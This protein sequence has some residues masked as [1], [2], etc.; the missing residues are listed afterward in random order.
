MPTLI[1]SLVV[2]LGIDS[3]DM[4]SKAPQATKKL[5]DVE[6]Q[7]EKTKSSIGELGRTVGTF[8]AIIGGSTAIKVFISDFIEANAQLKRLS[9]NLELGVST[10]S[11]WSQ[12]TEQLGGSAE[13]LQGTLDMLSKSQTQLRL[14]GESSLIPYLSALGVSLATVNGQAKPVTDILLD[15]SDRFSRMDRTTANNM[16]RMMGIDQGTMN[17]LLLG[18]KELETTIRRQRENTAVTRAQADEAQKLQTQIVKLKQNF[19]AFGRNL[20][21]SALPILEKLLGW[22]TKLGDWVRENSEFVGDFL[23]VMAVGLGAIAL[24]A[25]PIDLVVVAVLGLATAIALLWQD[26]QVWKRG[27]DSLIDWGKWE[28]GITAATRGIELLGH[29]A[30]A[31]LGFLGG[32]AAIGGNLINGNKAAAGAALGRMM[33]KDVDNPAT[34]AALGAYNSPQT[35]S[36]EYMMNYFKRR[37]VS[38]DHAAG[39]VASLMGESA[40][41]TRASGDH[42]HAYGLAQWQGPRQADFK[43]W[44][45]HDIRLSTADEQLAFVLHELGG[46]YK[47]A[48]DK[49]DGAKG[50]FASGDAVSRYY[51]RPMDVEG[52]ARARGTYAASL[53][54]QQSPAST[55]A[56]SRDVHIGEIKVYTQ[57]TDAPGIAKDIGG[58][59]DY[60]FTSQANAGL[61]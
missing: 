5:K 15:L 45:G 18:R 55:V 32:I 27:G 57:A 26:Y 24:V 28:P 10:I 35:V 1:D 47:S 6:D 29:A 34:Q 52:N 19:A 14:T 20:L 50:A 51:E 46:T 17:I 3:K 9:D 60:L 58:S 16:G 54:G 36:K 59:M 4:D 41:N 42:G 61:Q 33:G 38:S 2:K 30:K 56:G 22:L 44:A 48:G 39:I 37:G 49:L 40:G 21:E 25:V 11:A 13:G 31:T 53:A 8:L 7:S 23:K 43:K 12:A